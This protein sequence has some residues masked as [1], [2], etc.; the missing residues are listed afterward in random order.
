M[1]VRLAAEGDTD[2]SVGRKLLSDARLSV[3]DQVNAGGKERLDPKIPGFNKTAVFTPWLV[4]RDLDH[5]ADC[6]AELV[7]RLV[8]KPE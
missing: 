3:G 7:A 6:A 1:D 8:G 4:L 5:D 2:L